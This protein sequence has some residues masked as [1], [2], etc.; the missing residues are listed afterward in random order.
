MVFEMV[1]GATFDGS[2]GA[3]APF[4]RLVTFGMA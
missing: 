2:L 4:G 3:L 1:G